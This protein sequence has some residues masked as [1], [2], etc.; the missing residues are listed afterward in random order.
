MYYGVEQSTDLRNPQT[1]IVKFKSRKMAFLW[2]N[3]ANKS[4]RSTYG[5]PESARNWHHTF[6]SVFLLYGKINKKDSLFDDMGTSTYPRT[7]EDNLATYLYKYGEL[8]K[9]DT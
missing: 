9:T 7:F 5:D 1:V 8:Q 6:R 4:G 3:E 2:K